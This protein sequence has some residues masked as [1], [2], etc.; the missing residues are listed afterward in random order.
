[1]NPVFI[2]LREVLK[3]TAEGIELLSEYYRRYTRNIT[4]DPNCTYGDLIEA[5]FDCE[6]LSNIIEEIRFEIHKKN[7]DI[8]LEALKSG[9]CWKQILQDYNE[10]EADINSRKAM[11]EQFFDVYDR[12]IQED[13]QID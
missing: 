7:V 9:I 13:F 4:S 8:S 1:E 10:T 3:S 11:P 12:M 2:R 5:Y 6:D